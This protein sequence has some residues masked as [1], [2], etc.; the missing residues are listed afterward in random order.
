MAT[1]INLLIVILIAGVLF[2]LI[3]WFIAYIPVPEPFAMVV[4]VIIG[5][6]CLLYILNLLVGFAPGLQHGVLIR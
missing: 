6:I 3:N 2:W 4:R 5:L 1:L